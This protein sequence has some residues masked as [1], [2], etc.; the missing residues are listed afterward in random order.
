MTLWLITNIWEKNKCRKRECYLLALN[1][2]GNKVDRGKWNVGRTEGT[3]LARMAQLGCILNI[4]GGRKSSVQ[5]RDAYPGVYPSQPYGDA[6]ICASKIAGANPCGLEQP[7]SGHPAWEFGYGPSTM[8]RLHTPHTSGMPLAQPC[9][10]RAM[11][12]LES[13]SWWLR[14][15]LCTSADACASSVTD[16]VVQLRFMAGLRQRWSSARLLH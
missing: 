10:S 12:V 7:K 1:R 15:H 4:L 6:Q 2:G 13:C 9:D 14:W 16:C 3:I 5:A 8:S 11:L